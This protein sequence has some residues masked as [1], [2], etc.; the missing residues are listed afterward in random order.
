MKLPIVVCI[1]LFFLAPR[2]AAESTFHESE[3]N[4]TPPSFHQ[5]DGEVSL[6]GTL[7]GP[8]QDGFL[9]TVSDNDAR[10]RWNFELQGIPGA[11][12]IMDVVVLEYDD[13]GVDV[14]GKSSIMKMGSRDGSKPAVQDGLIFEPGEY[15]LGFAQMGAGSA[16]NTNAAYRPPMGGLSFVTEQVTKGDETQ[17]V[18]PTPDETDGAYR[19]LIREQKLNVQTNQKSRETRDTAYK[20]RL[21]SESSWFES[22][23]TAWYSFPFT[24]KDAQKRW[25]IHV[26]VPVGRTATAKLYNADGKELANDRTD[27]PG[28]LR[29]PDLAPPVGTWYLEVTTRD[30]GFIQLVASE[31][32]GVRVAGEEAEPNN[33]WSTANRVDLTQALTGR[34]G[35]DDTV[36]YFS[37]TVDDTSTDQLL[38]LRTQTEPEAQ[39]QICLTTESRKPLQCKSGSGQVELPDLL[40]T[41]G[42]WGFYL[43]R[44]TETNYAVSL[45]AQGPVTPGVEAEPNDHIESP[46][47]VPGN[48]RIKGRFVGNETDFYRFL[49]PGEPQLWRFQ[50]IG[51]GI[52]E[53]RHYDGTGRLNTS[54]RPQGERR[55]RFDNLFLLPGRHSLSVT[56]SDGGSYTVLARALGPPDPNGEIEPNDEHNKQ[57]LMV[58]QTRSGLLSEKNDNDYYRFFVADWDHLKLTIQPAADGVIHGNFYWYVGQIGQIIP[59]GPGEPLVM[60][61][62]FP[63]GDYYLNLLAKQASDAD[64][65]VSLE[66]LPR[67]TLPADSE[68][69]GQGH[70]WLAAALPPD[71]VLDGNSGEWRDWDYYQLPGFDSPA[72][73]LLLTAEA[74]ASLYVGTHVRVQQSLIHDAELGG[75][76]TII[77]AG[78]PYRIMIDSRK[79]PYRIQLEFPGAELVPVTGS[80]PAE[81]SLELDHKTVSAYRTNGQRVT[82]RLR[83]GNTGQAPLVAT[84][85]AVTSDLRWSVVAEQTAI[86]VPVGGQIDVPMEIRAPADVWADVP[87]R[88]S[89]RIADNAGR[90]VET[91]QEIDVDREIPAVSP[92]LYWAIPET[93]RGG[94][95]AAWIPF[96]GEWTEDTPK[97]ITTDPLRDN[98]VFPQA[99]AECCSDGDGWSDD[100]RPLLTIDLPGED[101]LP[102]RGVAINHFGTTAT[103]QNIRNATVLLSLDG[104]SF[105]E[106]LDFEAVR[107]NNEQQFALDAPVPAR[108]AR[109]RVN[110]TFQEPS[111]NRLFAAE[112][113]VILEPGYDL[114]GGTG[115][116]IADKALG[117]HVV[118][119][120]PPKPYLPA[121][122][123]IEDGKGH[124]AH[125]LRG[126]TKKD[127]V[128]G[129]NENRAAQIS[130]IDWNYGDATA[131]EHRNFANVAVSAST[132]SPV[133]PWSPLGEIDLSDGRIE[134][135]LELSAPA[136]ARFVKLTA[137][138]FETGQTPFAPDVIR[139]W[140]R[141]TDN[142]YRSVITE[143]GDLTSRA[144][145]ELQAGLQPEAELKPASNT[146]R[147]RAAMLAV[148]QSAFGQVSLAKQEHWYRLTVPPGDNILTLQLEGDPTVRTRL[149]LE[150]EDGDAIPFKRNP[151][152]E[153]PARHIMEA[154]V[155]PGS[156]VWMN[157]AEPPRNVVFT[158]DT[159]A[160]VNAYIHT[161]NN[162]LV[163]FSSQVVPG[164]E[165]VNLMPFSNTLL[166]DEWYGEPYK[167]QTTLNDY[168]RVG[169]SSSAH[170]TLKNAVSSMRDLPGTKAVVMITDAD[171]PN[172]GGVWGPLQEVQPRVF[173]IG[174]AGDQRYQQDT[175]RDWSSVNGGH[176]TQLRYDG[177]MEVAFDRATTLMHRPA[178]YTL[179]ATTEYREAPGPGLL[180]VVSGSGDGDGSESSTAAVELILDASGS[181][182][183]RIDGKRRIV[184]AKEVLTEA[185]RKHI[186]PGTPVALR[187]F[188]HKEVDSCRT[189][190]E[191]PLAPLDPEAAVAKIA[192]INA[193]NLARTPIADSLAAV[194]GDLNA[195]K[196]GVIILVTDGE[197]TCEGNPGAVIEQLRSSGFSVRLNIVGFAIDDAVLAAQFESWAELG[198]GRYLGASD[199]AGLSEAIELALRISYTVYDR[200]GNEVATGEVGGEPLELER[201]SYRVVVNSMPKET[202]D[203]VT[204]QG[205]DSLT[206]KLRE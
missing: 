177:E 49:I 32:V 9:W 53:I 166:L 107:L 154:I 132:E 174:V 41:P 80:L 92:Y 35:G 37:F 64:Y 126:D 11:L 84:L 162:S 102:V 20:M 85:E 50:V 5:I 6:S 27:K 186:P 168:R 185:V 188:G 73:L 163:A 125:M 159:S 30:P 120:W 100:E 146:T 143:W 56:G 17:A 33:D 200:G 39:H 130:R 77:P 137:T 158:W 96:G 181:M 25:D 54:I 44:A 21:G 88:I 28:R 83:I 198:G 29:F 86:S 196:S 160:S 191:I 131:A 161:I 169:S 183:K 87:V 204:L 179:V 52:F 147:P 203:N 75:Y 91:W 145:Y 128:I 34:I 112:W 7:L 167:L 115:F 189:D 127:Y 22:H 175:L 79:K 89:A 67:F 36:D 124:S 180:S 4:D 123:V 157:V 19:F 119:D 74:V 23:A 62:L 10:E 15:V 205:E 76:R 72:E 24:E 42:T 206:L 153:T 171:S 68:P 82:G 65:S 148:D 193:M 43:G 121:G 133:G 111:N 165:A 114:S 113:K 90:Q 190:L 176:F 178:G 135:S 197:E 140:E 60:E 122:I 47:A 3:P 103:F 69:N 110:A 70:I 195:A 99:Y 97:S 199:Q 40:L 46:S 14:T 93:L 184:V 129:F 164:R 138:R 81:L 134:A 142:E 182:L 173:S 71:L 8:D 136:W 192:D 18:E 144:Y 51:D 16:R 12:T 117:G 57:R 94:F 13:N 95:N 48:L 58:G 202:F 116:N 172:D 98:L 59:D 108:F 109:L 141:P 2:A 201:G 61:G 106:V 101:P 170:G 156:Q 187:V 118:W 38:T 66:R 149:A 55:I 152:K 155:D 139:I 45:E 1:C 31:S 194:A 150:N 104:I 105:E 63:P 26:Q 78:K 151:S